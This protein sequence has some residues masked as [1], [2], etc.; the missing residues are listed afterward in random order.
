MK[1]LFQNLFVAVLII[2]VAGPS[3][4]NDLASEPS[5]QLAERAKDT[6]ISMFSS[7][8]VYM[9]THN[10]QFGSFADLQEDELIH[11]NYTPTT[12]AEGYE[13]YIL[14]SEFVI[15]EEGPG[16]MNWAPLVLALPNN[17]TTA[18]L[19]GFVVYA[20]EFCDVYNANTVP[21][22][23]VACLVSVSEVINCRPDWADNFSDL[24]GLANRVEAGYELTRNDYNAIK[25]GNTEEWVLFYCP[26]RNG[27]SVYFNGTIYLAITPEDARREGD[28]TLSSQA[29]LAQLVIDLSDQS[30]AMGTLR[31]FGSTQ[32]AYQSTNDA[33]LYGFWHGLQSSLYISSDKTPTT[34]V[35]GYEM[36][37]LLTEHR[38]RFLMV[39]EGQ[40]D[41]LNFYAITDDQLLLKLRLANVSDLDL[42]EYTEYF[43][44]DYYC[45]EWNKYE[46][47]MIT[48][49]AEIYYPF[50]GNCSDEYCYFCYQSAEKTYVYF[51]KQLYVGYPIS[52]YP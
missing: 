33:Q 5:D 10:Q 52:I 40:R 31:S 11:P 6:A 25:Y 4:S 20:N 48:P 42:T 13:M 44:E 34:L 49:R 12:I 17:E 43:T 38:D 19:V 9:A 18:S 7:E 8:G 45:S 16:G 22:G 32:L 3:S 46:M 29:E 39:I 47:S 27:A 37:I 24:Q 1:A 51:Q 23:V 36:H 30:R 15:E 14:Q 21:A 50:S 35:E 28:S 41:G 26:Y 2:L